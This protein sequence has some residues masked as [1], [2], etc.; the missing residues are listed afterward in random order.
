MTSPKDF[1]Y[2]KSCEKID[3]LCVDA[4]FEL[5]ADPDLATGIILK[6]SWEDTGIDLE[7]M[8]KAGETDTF[9]ALTPTL[10][11]ESL[12]YTS[13]K[14]V[15]CITGHDLSRII[16][17]QFLKD[18]DQNDSPE[19]GDIYKMGDNNLFELF[20]LDDFIENLEGDLGDI[21]TRITNLEGIVGSH[22]REINTIKERLTDIEGR[23]T[24]I[25]NILEKPDNIPTNAR[26]AWGNINVYGDIT[27]NNLKTSGIYTHNPNT[28]VINDQ[29]FS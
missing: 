29:Y 28:N 21:I 25:E 26:V 18:V 24:T 2:D 17:M 9:L 13:E 4:F 10:N 3:P 14:H 20:N 15:D 16:S 27:N 5:T 7:P 1:F 22:T 11:P 19:P 12:Q 8:I 23:L 6:N